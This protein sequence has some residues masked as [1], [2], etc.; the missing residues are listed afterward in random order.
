LCGSSD[1][2]IKSSM[3]FVRKSSLIKKPPANAA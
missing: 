2:A 3:L 1:A